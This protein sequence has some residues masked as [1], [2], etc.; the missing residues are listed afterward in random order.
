[1]SDRPIPAL[2]GSPAR[3][4][5]SVYS[6]EIQLKSLTLG[7]DNIH[8]D[9][10]LSQRFTEA[11]RKYIRD[12]VAQT[13]N[14]SQIYGAGVKPARPPEASAFR[15]LLADFCQ[16]SLTRAQFEKNI[17][18]DL[19]YRLALLKFLTQEIN[20]QFAELLLECKEWMRGRG[21]YFERSE[22]AHVIKARLAEL[23]AG[24][25]NVF[26]LVGQQLHQMLLELDDSMLSKSRRA[27][28]QDDFPNEYAILKNRLV[29]VE[30]GKDDLVSLEHYVLL[31]NFV[32]DPDRQ[33]VV[34]AALFQF[35]K[36][37]VFAYP[38]DP[39]LHAAKEEHRQLSEQ[40]LRL[41]GELAR[42]EE[43]KAT[44]AGRLDRSGALLTRLTGGQDP[45]TLRAA[46]REI[47]GRH[48]GLEQKLTALATKLEDAA[49]KLDYLNVEYNTKIEEYLYVPEN[50]A[51]LF[52]PAWKGSGL[53]WPPETR[54]ALVTQWVDWLKRDD[55]LLHILASYELRGLY[56]EYC[57]PLHLQQLKR[58]L[59]N[60]ADLEQV[61]EIARQYPA[62][63]LSLKRVEE[64]SKA[65]RR[66]AQ[67]ELESVAIRF[68]ADLLH[69][70]RDQRDYARLVALM[71]RISLVRTER[72]RELSR[73]NNSLYE[74]LLSDD[75]KPKEDRVLSHT[76][77]KADVRSSSKI[78][79]DLIAR[80]LNP[81]AH[82]SLHLH[83]PVKGILERY[84]AAKVFIEG[85][86]IIL[87]IYE[88]ESN[89]AHQRAVAKS[90]VLARKILELV[91]AYNQRAAAS[92]LPPLELGLGVAFQNSPPTLWMDSDSRIMI[93]RALNLSDRLSSCSKVA[94]RILAQ[95]F[96]PFNVFLFQTAIEGAQEE[97]VEELLIRYN[98]NGVEINV[99]GFRKLQEEMALK[100]TEIKCAMP[101]GSETVVLHTGEVLIG[102]SFEPIVVRKGTVRMLEPDGTIGEA[103]AH[104]YYEVCSNSQVLQLLSQRQ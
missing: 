49:R 42:L 96:T 23:Q 78:T 31:G 77:I 72:A 94:R 91:Q 29:F 70:R 71:E 7:T 66:C 75:E 36:E 52:D 86:A 41:R 21:E 12:L 30:G 46:I 33:D 1:M 69:L 14:L 13:A 34:E 9:V 11:A 18:L 85:D 79:Q 10:F 15:K 32:R 82:F 39:A 2:A 47:E 4:V 5:L 61:E 37:H 104:D 43:E 83:Q 64:R 55:L 62:K 48:A 20:A 102:D 40:A 92:D 95:N 80:G 35:A 22:Q 54:A 67:S 101:W 68:A 58:A 73:L 38:P 6:A 56:R 76:I 81:A 50:A 3:D 53:T 98:L 100:A 89:R 19:L 87:A 57:P 65:F 24:R 90:C 93:S 84:G 88:N 60:R 26:R 8:Y 45:D 25:R 59:V 103:G 44:L 16:C 74:F 97:E 99:E 27:L 17:E 63:G 28:F 51:R